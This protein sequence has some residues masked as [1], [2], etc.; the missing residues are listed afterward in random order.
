MNNTI[1]VSGYFCNDDIKLLNDYQTELRKEN[2][3]LTY[4]NL[5]NTIMHSALDFADIELISFSYELIRTFVINGGYDV[6]K[7]IIA[8]LWSFTYQRTKSKTVF[9]I[10]IKGIPTYDNEENIKCKVSGELSEELK[11]EVIDKAFNLANKIADNEYELLERSK[12]YDAFNAHIFA[13][14]N[15]KFTLSEIDIDEEVRK[16]NIE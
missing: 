7:H 9:T 11:K 16:R 13:L 14:D 12:Y 2:I 15:E 10:E 4:R 3:A 5:S 1:Y 8:K 6:F